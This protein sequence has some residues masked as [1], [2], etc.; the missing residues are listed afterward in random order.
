MNAFGNNFRVALYG[1]SHGPEVG[2]LLDGV[3]PGILLSEADFM[4]DIAR[5]K[6]GPQ[7]PLN[8]GKRM[9]L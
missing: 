3:P 7:E 8:V 5:R 1:E 6:A 4:E 9:N 2:V